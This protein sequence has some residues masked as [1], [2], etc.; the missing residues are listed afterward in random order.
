MSQASI[1]LLELASVVGGVTSAVRL[2]AGGTA[3]NAARKASA[4][5]ITG[6]EEILISDATTSR[7]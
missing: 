5:T 2:T 6:S 4:V 1:A 7:L 3:A